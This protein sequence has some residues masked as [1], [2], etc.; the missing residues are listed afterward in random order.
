MSLGE[1]R[2]EA[3]KVSRASFLKRSVKCEEA[4]EIELR[5]PLMVF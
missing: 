1:E 5:E 2:D 4:R 3:G